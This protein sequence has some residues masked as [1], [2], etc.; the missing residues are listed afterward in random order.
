MLPSTAALSSQFVPLMSAYIRCP[1]SLMYSR[2]MVVAALVCAVRCCAVPL[3][4]SIWL[5][6]G[7]VRAVRD[8]RKSLFP[9]GVIKVVGDFSAQVGGLGT[10]RKNISNSSSGMRSSSSSFGDL[11]IYES[12][13]GSTVIPLETAM[14]CSV[15]RWFLGVLGAFSY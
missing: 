7:A 5:D 11:A 14:L 3:R 12:H 15:L 2:V 1:S 10:A 4:G 9:V 8:K 13:M 6:D